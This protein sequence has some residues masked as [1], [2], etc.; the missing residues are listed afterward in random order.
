MRENSA[1]NRSDKDKVVQVDFSEHPVKV[2]QFYN[3]HMG[4]LLYDFL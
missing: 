2:D 4:D 3:P 1:W